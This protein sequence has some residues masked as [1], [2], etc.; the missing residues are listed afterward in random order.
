MV[1]RDKDFLIWLHARLEK[2][3]KEPAVADYM[4]KLGSIIKGTPADR[5]T[6]NCVGALELPSELDV[7]EMQKV[8]QMCFDDTCGASGVLS[9]KTVI[10]L[11]KHVDTSA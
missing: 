10:E 7:A 11:M 8:L 4:R 3:H 1:M 9:K 5:E 2:V 6:P